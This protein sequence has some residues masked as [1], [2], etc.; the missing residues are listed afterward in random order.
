[1]LY[2]SFLPLR[3]VWPLAQVLK[4]QPQKPQQKQPQK[5][6]TPLLKALK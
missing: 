3:S 1:L 5:L 2:L 4:K 6:L